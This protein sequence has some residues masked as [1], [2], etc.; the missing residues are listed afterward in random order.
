METD[1]KLETLKKKKKGNFS[2]DKYIQKS[3]IY[4]MGIRDDRHRLS[5][6]QRRSKKISKLNTRNEK[7]ET[8]IKRQRGDTETI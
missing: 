8:K 1:R 4:S 6:L 5:E 7:Q 3:G 2:N